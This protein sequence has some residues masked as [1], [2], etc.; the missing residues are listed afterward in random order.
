MIT[1]RRTRPSAISRRTLL[2]STAAGTLAAAGIAAWDRAPAFAQQ[3][4]IHFLLNSNFRA[5][6]DVEIKK[7]AAEYTKLSGVEVSTEFIT[8]NDVPARLTAAIE[9]GIGMDLSVV[10]WNQ[11]HLYENGLVD[12]GDIVAGAGGDRIY[13]AMRAADQ[14]KSV[15]RAFPWYVI[16][17]SMTYNKVLCEKAGVTKFPDTYDELLVAGKKMKQAGTPV[18]WCL[19]HTNGDGAF[20]NYPIFWSFGAMEVDD[21]GKVAIN[22]K[23]ARLAIEWMRQFWADACDESGMGWND[24]S[25]NQ[26]F[27]ARQIACAYNPSSI[28]LKARAAAKAARDK[29]DQATAD[30][31]DGLAND[32]RHTVGPAGPAGRFHLNQPVNF[33]IL[34]ASPNVAAAKDFMR[35]LVAKPQY[36]RCFLAGSGFAQ[37]N[38]PDWEK[39]PL[40]DADPIIAPF[41]QITKYGRNLGYK[42]PYN[43]AS[44]EVQNKYLI[45]DTLA[46]GIREGADA[47]LKWA[48][49][50]MTAIY[51]RA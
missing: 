44:A 48:E 47:A 26:A 21:K 49:L 27:L 32:T 45:A 22:S 6:F 30:L 14:V 2:K 1:S 12:V 37:G 7:L 42:G 35:W 8:N 43:R 40:W 19:G 3:R 20:G 15:F 10:Q 5:S 18:G 29:G 41:A 50:E 38:T 25:N 16:T 17:S 4:K 9:S 46:R 34:R 11:A 28:Y 24:S 39:H 13:P 36:E 23:E 33:G 31:W 51:S